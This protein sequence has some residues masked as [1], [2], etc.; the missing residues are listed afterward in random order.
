MVIYDGTPLRTFDVLPHLEKEFGKDKPVLAEKENGEWRTYSIEESQGIIDKVSKALLAFGIKK[1]D[2]VAISSRNCP[3]W[4]FIDWGIQ[5]VGG[6]TVPLYTTI[7]ENDYKYNLNHSEAKLLFIYG[8]S[9]YRK[10]ETIREEI[11]TVQKVICMK[12]IEGAYGLDEFLELGKDVPRQQLEEAMSQVD[13]YDLATVIYTSGTTGTPKGVMLTHDN[14]TSN[15][16]CLDTLFYVHPGCRFF[17]YLPLSHIFERQ[18]V[19]AYMNLGATVYYTENMATILNDIQEVKPHVFTT[20]PRLLEKVHA[21][22]LLKGKKLKGIKKLI[23]NW[24]INLG[25]EFNAEHKNSKW[26]NRKLKVADKLVYQQVRDTL[27]NSLEVIILGGASIQPKIAKL[28][29]AMKMPVMEGYGLTET[30]PVIAV[31]SPVTG[32]IKIGTVGFPVDNVDV[33][34]SD[35]GEITVKGSTVM[36]GYYKAPEL[37]AEV[38]DSEGYFHTGDLGAIDK[39]G[40]LCLTGRVKEI[41]KTSMGK[42]VSPSLVENTM[43]QSPYI[44]SIIVVGE[45]QKFA[46]ALI[47]PNFDQ[48]NIWCRENNLSFINN[49]LMVKDKAVIALMRKEVDRLNKGLGDY[50]R[51]QRFELLPSD[52]SAGKGEITSTMKIRRDVIQR[53]YKDKI[54][55][56]FE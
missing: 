38:I 27:G 50:E 11:P 8:Q 5:Q 10:I 16:K 47:I 33:K 3:L 51:V 4:N 14:M 7:S 56:M 22:V 40:F 21:S 19:M 41:F 45:G 2:R 1:G 53:H 23:F 17:S 55:K 26:Y 35:I 36:K 42:Y 43:M 15:T 6:I 13:R 49:E 46:A 24:A 34:I 20:I 48:L 31:N 54:D 30:S 18:V 12:P 32:N 29:T 25:Y 44:N 28:L 9:I 37:T 39:D 52:W